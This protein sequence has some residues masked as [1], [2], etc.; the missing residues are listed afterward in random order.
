M[1]RVRTAVLLFAC[2]PVLAGCGGHLGRSPGVGGEGGAGG[3]HSNPTGD[4]TGGGGTVGAGGAA[5]VGGA[6]FGEPACAPSVESGEICAPTDE[7][8]CYRRCG[9]DREALIQSS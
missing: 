5:G 6:K 8:F 7:Q 1:P 9:P 4:P 2:V 3:E